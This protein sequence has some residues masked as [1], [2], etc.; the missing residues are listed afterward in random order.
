MPEPIDVLDSLGRH[1]LVDGYDFVL[2]LEKSSGT[3][4]VEA[5][6]GE[7]YL[8]LFTFFSS[9]PL[10]MNHAGLAQDESFLAKLGRA[11]LHKVSNH[12]MYTAEYAEFVDTFARVLGDPELPHLFFIDG[13]ALAVENALKVAFDWK[14]QRPSAPADGGQ[15]T[16]LHLT[17]AFHGRSGYTMSMTNTDPAKTLRYPQFDWPRL[18]TPEQRFPEDR[19]EA[20]NRR[21][22]EEALRE[23]HT[24]ME[25][26][27]GR[28]AC[29]I[30]EPILGEGGDIHLSPGFL[31]GMQELCREFDALFVVD[32]VQTGCGATGTAWAYQQ[33]GLQ[34]DVVAFGKKTQVCGV[35]AGR[36][37][38]LVASNVFAVPSRISSTWGGNLAD[39]VRGTRILEIIEK[40]GLVP[41]AAAHG[42]VLLDLLRDLERRHPDLV[43]NAR[44]RGLMTAID[45]PDGALRDGVVERLR[46]EEHV[47]ALPSGSRTLRFRPPL[48]ITVHE[49]TTAVGAIDRVLSTISEH[50]TRIQ[51]EA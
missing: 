14:A 5:R 2:D 33:L 43:T 16:A 45:L 51:E 38:D 1:I 46:S 22:D 29:F 49:L 34:P 27:G 7:E 10:G 18:T 31:R 13:G 4:L 39:M 48:T 25:E 6:S 42:A 36:R 8:D 50:T 26:A 47:M 3:T 19:W 44:G 9:L 40:D 32:E 35:M 41:A 11:A 37:V 15:L 20:E 30:A 23:A 24:L 12:D 28:I 17:S 21:A